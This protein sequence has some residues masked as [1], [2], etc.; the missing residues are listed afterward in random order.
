MTPESQGKLYLTLTPRLLNLN[1]ESE[2]REE[3]SLVCHLQAEVL[4]Y[5]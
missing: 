4:I 3:S 5:L 1:L 2:M